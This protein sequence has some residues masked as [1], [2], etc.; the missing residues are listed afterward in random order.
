MKLKKRTTTHTEM[1]TATITGI[2]PGSCQVPATRSFC[3]LGPSLSIQRGS[4]SQEYPGTGW[5]ITKKRRKAPGFSHGDI[6]R[7][8]LAM[9]LKDIF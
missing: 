1:Q 5:S 6:R 4:H 9:L 7:D 2:P 3:Y 8:W